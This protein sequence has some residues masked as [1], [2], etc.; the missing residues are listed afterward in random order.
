MEEEEVDEDS[1][2]SAGGPV[3][4]HGRGNVARYWDHHQCYTV[5]D[6][7]HYTRIFRHLLGLLHL[8]SGLHGRDENCAG[9][10]DPHEDWKNECGIWN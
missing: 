4:S 6:A 8:D 7:S 9:E 5:Q 1:H 10:G 3:E 2:G